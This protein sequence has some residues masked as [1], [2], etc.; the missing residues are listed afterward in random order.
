MVFILSFLS[1]EAFLS[2]PSS[3][4]FPA[5]SAARS[6]EMDPT[7]AVMVTVSSHS[8]RELGLLLGPGLGGQGC[9]NLNVCPKPKQTKL[10]KIPP[11]LGDRLPERA[12]TAVQREILQLPSAMVKFTGA[13]SSAEERQETWPG[14]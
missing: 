11:S 9:K 2:Q 13:S 4:A 3:R 6:P 7:W 1:Y 8:P 14:S 12:G 10:K 5:S